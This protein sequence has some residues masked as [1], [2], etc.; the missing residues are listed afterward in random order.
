[1]KY[2]LAM[3]CPQCGFD[4]LLYLKSKN[5]ACEQVRLHL[6]KRKN[7]PSVY[8]SSRPKLDLPVIKKTKDMMGREKKVVVR[9]HIAKNL[10]LKL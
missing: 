9:S 6:E 7:D 3:A 8:L 1:M 4:P 5:K 10:D 2:R